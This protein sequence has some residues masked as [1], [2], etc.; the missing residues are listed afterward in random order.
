MQRQKL[1]FIIQRGYYGLGPW[2]TKPGDVCFI[3]S[4][5]RVPFVLRR[6]NDQVSYK[7]VGEAYIHSI[8]H[9]EFLKE[10]DVGVGWD[11]LTLI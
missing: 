7:V 5:A 9:G 10:R 8:M 6:A 1:F 3:L 11:D 2:T 4:G